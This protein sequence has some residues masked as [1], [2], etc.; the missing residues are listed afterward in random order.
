VIQRILERTSGRSYESFMSDAVFRPLGM[1][2]TSI[3]TGAGLANAAV[4]YGPDGK[5]LP[6][7]DTDHRGASGVYTSAHELARFAMFLLRDRQKGQTPILSDK[8]LIAMQRVATPGES[9]QGYG[10]GIEVDREDGRTLLMHNGGMPGVDV[11]LR[12]YPAEDIAVVVLTNSEGEVAGE[13]ADAIR[14]VMLPK[15]PPSEPASSDHGPEP[16]A[17]PVALQ[18][19]W[20]GTVRIFDGTTI[21]FA[22]RVKPDDVHVRLGGPGTLTTVLNGARFI[23]G[24]QVLIGI[25]D[26]SMPTA[27]TKGRRYYVS[28]ALW[29]DGERMRGRAS[30]VLKDSFGETSLPAYAELK[31]R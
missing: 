14:E 19:E 4:R 15:P 30:A 29:F 18:G 24:I 26:A 31:R 20:A 11:T 28:I 10:L 2:T 7:Y 6:F 5:P 8:S 27:D 22:M 23:S 21:P 17:A 13:V 3:G 1:P 12:M 25:F 16:F 9:T